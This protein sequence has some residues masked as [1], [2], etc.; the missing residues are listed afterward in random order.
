MRS[1]EVD[2]LVQLSFAVQGI[3]NRIAADN[4]LSMT[5]VR[6]LGILRDREPGMMQLAEYLGLDKSSVTGLVDRAEKRGLV[7][8]IDN[9]ADGRAT[10]VAITASGRALVRRAS[11]EVDRQIDQLLTPLSTSDRTTLASIATKIVPAS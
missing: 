5:Q 11:H 6:L 1:E 10:Q 9:P 7:R 2:G 3:L 4:D 8:R